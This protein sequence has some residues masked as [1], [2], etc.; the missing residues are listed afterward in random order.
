MQLAL[1]SY[2]V[3][4]CLD[5]ALD[6]MDIAV[7]VVDAELRL[8]HT[9]AAARE[10]LQRDT[11]LRLHGDKLLQD[12][13]GGDKSLGQTVAAVLAAPGAT[14]HAL[15]LPRPDRQP[16]LLT[17]VPFAPATCP[18]E[19]PACA[20][21]MASDPDHY[22]LSPLL[23]IELF[24]LTPA[25]AGVAQA[26]ARGAAL[27]DI[28]AALEIS[29]HTVKTHLQKLFRKTGTRRQGEL[30]SVLHGVPA[31]AVRSIV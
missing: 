20:I 25:E 22:R 15:S 9:N 26:L 27:E 1:T 7:F 13:A 12:A 5:A 8:L 6:H 10:L 16:L 29:L 4:S 28:A 18:A 17:V 31:A 3:A 30:V 14:A 23:L 21:V 11:A 2:A 19:L 24:G